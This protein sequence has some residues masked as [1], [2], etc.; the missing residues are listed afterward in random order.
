MRVFLR[1]IFVC[2]W[3]ACTGSITDDCKWKC[4]HCGRMSE[5]D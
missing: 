1:R 4:R 2:W 5:W 3:G